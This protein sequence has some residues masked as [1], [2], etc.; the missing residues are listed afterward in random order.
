[1]SCHFQCSLRITFSNWYSFDW[2]WSNHIV[3][4]LTKEAQLRRSVW[5]DTHQSLTGSNV[6]WAARKV[7][8]IINLL[9]GIFRTQSVIVSRKSRAQ[10]RLNWPFDWLGKRSSQTSFPQIW[11]Y[12]HSYAWILSFSCM[13]QDI[14]RI[15]FTLQKCLFV[16]L[17]I[18]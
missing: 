6:S 3:R 14:D 11:K 13:D 12:L 18:Y 16:D 15:F 2:E 9:D 7:T 5:Y 1:M 17:R 8:E 4:N 10:L